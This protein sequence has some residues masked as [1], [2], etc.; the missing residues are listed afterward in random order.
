[1]DSRVT[2]FLQVASVHALKE[3]LA[4]MGFPSNGLKAALRVRL[5]EAARQLDDERMDEFFPASNDDSSNEEDTDENV[6]END[7]EQQ[8]LENLRRIVARKEEILALQ[9]RLAELNSPCESQANSCSFRDIEDSLQTFS[10]DDSLPISKWIQS[11][12]HSK[13]IY[14]FD[15]SKCFIFAQ[16]MLKG[17]AKLFLRST[18]C[19]SWSE[20]KSALMNEF[21]HHASASDVHNTLRN[22][23]KRKEENI[24]QYVLTM[25]E[26]AS[27]SDIEENDVISYI[28]RGIPDSSF[29]KQILFTANTIPELKTVLRR[30]ERMKLE[31]S[32]GSTSAFHHTVQKSKTSVQPSNKFGLKCFNCNEAGHVSSKCPKPPRERGS[33]FG[34]GERGH[35]VKNCPKSSTVCLVEDADNY[36]DASI[37]RNF[38]GVLDYHLQSSEY[39]AVNTKLSA[40]TMI[41]TG[42]PISFV[43]QKFIPTYL[44]SSVETQPED[45]VGINNSKLII[46]VARSI[47]DGYY[48]N[49]GSIN[50]IEMK[51]VL[52]DAN[53]VF[54]CS[55]RRLPFAH[56]I[57][58]NKILDDLLSRNVIRESNSPFA[59]PIVLAKKKTGELRLCVD[60]RELNKITIKDNFPLPIIEDILDGL[61]NKRYFTLLDLKNGFQHVKMADDSTKLTSFVTPSGQI[62]NFSKWDTSEFRWC[63]SSSTFPYS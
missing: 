6:P 17:T 34:C 2:K 60:Y 39:G 30:Y 37:F 3:K 58:L 22:R 26:I 15:E 28:I 43:Q 5:E 13:E 10:G 53:S 36:D 62:P 11:F 63:E 35:I 55:P 38:H 20:L 18:S 19:R 29:N 50:D 32:S 21:S 61:R 9:K 46:L 27:S 47:S 40:L 1:M 41:D 33:C 49:N 8:Q 16:R 24:Q 45:F 14:N 25:L 51:I 59:S 52:K 57:E 4:A 12:E 23:R 31:C 7:V 42:S 48:V 54:S 56:K 44:T